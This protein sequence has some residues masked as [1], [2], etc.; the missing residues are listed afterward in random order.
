MTLN[1]G[2][3]GR[4][5]ESDRGLRPNHPQVLAGWSCGLWRHPITEIAESATICKLP[6]SPCGTHSGIVASPCVGR[7]YFRCY[8][9]AQAPYVLLCKKGLA[10]LTSVNQD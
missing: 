5:P 9:Q 10:Q 7:L 4:R 1:G 3:C 2:G 6:V 8:L